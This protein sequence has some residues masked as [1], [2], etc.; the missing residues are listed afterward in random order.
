MFKK[1]KINKTKYELLTFEE[2]IN[3]YEVRE[4]FINR[5]LV[6]TRYASRVIL[7]ELQQYMSAR[8]K[9]TKIHVVRGKFTHQIR[10]KWGL[11]RS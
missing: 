2:D 4:R 10:K 11:E 3:K 5:N 8:D 6:D 1:N 9:D 7:N